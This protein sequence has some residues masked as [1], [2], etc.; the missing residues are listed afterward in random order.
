ME[1]HVTVVAALQVGFGI[2]GLALGVCALVYFTGL[3]MAAE[4]SVLS[5]IGT[6]FGGFLFLVSVPGT[7]GGIGLFLRKNWARFPVL[8]ISAIY[9]ICFPFG[10]ALGIYSIW[11]LFQDDT[12]RLLKA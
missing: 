6:I 10:T 8:I 11:V 2:L 1:K 5:T 7:I 3:D 12:I 4:D 9:L